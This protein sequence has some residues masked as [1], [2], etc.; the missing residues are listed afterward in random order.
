ME[1]KQ[2]TVDYYRKIEVA[3][4]YEELRYGDEAGKY[5]HQKEVHVLLKELPPL[6]DLN[7]L[8]VGVGTGRL[9]VELARRGAQVLGF[10][11]SKTML[12]VLKKKI[13]SS[14]DLLGIDIVL[15]DAERLPFRDH[16]FSAVLSA[17]TLNHIPNYKQ[18]LKEMCRVSSNH[19]VVIVTYLISVLAP[20]PLVVNPLRKLLKKL[21]VYSKYFWPNEITKILMDEGLSVQQRG[22]H[23]IPPKV[24]SFTLLPQSLLKPIDYVG[25][26]IERFLRKVYAIQ[27]TMGYR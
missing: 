6:D 27:V 2:V 9:A 7:V 4:K 19:I 3:E 23:L 26:I 8:D 25:R 14:T 17:Y 10:D 12:R 11:T 15:G 13:R 24:L 22:L 5:M 16:T 1:D 21:P 18:A 20:I